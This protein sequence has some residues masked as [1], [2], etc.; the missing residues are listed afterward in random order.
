MPVEPTRVI[1][2]L[3]TVNSVSYIY[4]SGTSSPSTKLRT[5]SSMAIAGFSELY[6]FLLLA[7]TLQSV[8][9]PVQAQQEYVANHQLDCQN[10]NFNS[11]TKGYLKNG[12]QSSCQSYITFRSG[13]PYTTPISIGFLL[14]AV[15]DQIASI[16]NI[17]LLT[18]II[19]ADDQ[20][21]VPVNCSAAG[22][23]YQHNATYTRQTDAETYF[24][25]AN[26]TYQGL[27][28]CQALMDQNP[29]NFLD[30]EVGMLIKV[31]LRCACPTSNQTADGVKYLLTY[32]VTIGDTI[33]AIADTFRVNE[34]SL[35]DANKL[36]SEGLIFPFT[37]LLVPLT[38]EPTKIQTEVPA[39]PPAEPPQ[40]PAGPISDSTSSNKWVFVG[41]GLGVGSF[42]LLSLCGLVFC[43]YRRRF[44]PPPPTKKKPSE[45]SEYSALPEQNKSWSVSLSSHGVR[46]AIE[47]LTL[48]KFEDLRSA[49]GNFSESNRVKG[50]VY[51][52]SFMGDYAAVKVVK[53]DVSGEI[54]LLKK[55]NHSNIVRLSGLCVHD[56]NTYL[57]YEYAENGS[58]SDWL[59]SQKHETSFTLSWK[60]RVQIARDIADALNYVQNYINPSHIHKNLKSSNILLDSNLRA[61][62]SN[63]GLARSLETNG[64]GNLQLTRHVV[65]TQGYMA[66]EY[67][68]NGV[69]TPKLDV[70]AFGV[71]MLEL[72]SGKEAATKK[73]EEGEEL[74]YT[75]ITRVFQGDN[76]REKLKGFIDPCL[77]SEYPLD[78]AFSMAHLAKRCV[79]QDLNL[80][81][82]MAEILMTLSKILS[83]SLDWDPS[84]EFNRSTS[85]SSGR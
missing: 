4:L 47:S 10:K 72:L 37:P 55:I 60:L 78:L 46:Y 41:V 22:P 79:S 20:L 32:M 76:V 45:S 29:V 70:F 81:P 25:I 12:P 6:I 16:N 15:P 14:N 58:L 31:P 13:Q 17:S 68:E 24:S 18:A 61:K 3:S 82:S 9:E 52:G 69:I 2:S 35:L 83:S 42:L 65:G 5:H 75:S 56:G 80:R 8:L 11:T 27:S 59:H 44:K 38:T 43:L 21:V 7:A 49:T 57:V 53:G 51:R 40:S 34:T 26:D 28:T 63:F 23:Y 30:L 85:Q 1:L 77:G 74:L 54:N 48:Y 39:P 71:I 64:E 84:D 62:I 73:K 66:P 50:S 19:P 67:I 36:T 33:S